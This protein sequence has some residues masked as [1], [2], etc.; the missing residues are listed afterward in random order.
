MFQVTE[1]RCISLCLICLAASFLALELHVNIA[2]LLTRYHF[3]LERQT[4]RRLESQTSILQQEQLEQSPYQEV[5]EVQII[6][7]DQL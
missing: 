5:I 7:N 2:F 6:R 1:L 3:P 4:C